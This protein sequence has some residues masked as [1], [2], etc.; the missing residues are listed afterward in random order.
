MLC[1]CFDLSLKEK[2]S[3]PRTLMGSYKSSLDSRCITQIP[4]AYFFSGPTC[5]ADF[6]KFVKGIQR[7]YKG[8]PIPLTCRLER[9]FHLIH[10][11]VLCILYALGQSQGI[12]FKECCFKQSLPD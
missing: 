4:N 12:T 3:L 5:V 9:V 7:A 1:G 8:L 10:D 2:S 11:S 6:A